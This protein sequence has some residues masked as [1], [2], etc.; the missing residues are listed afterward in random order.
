LLFWLV[1]FSF[2]SSRSSI[3]SLQDKL[4]NK[5]KL[6]ETKFISFNL[7]LFNLNFNR[8]AIRNIYFYIYVY[9]RCLK[10]DNECSK[11]FFQKLLAFYKPV[12]CRYIVLKFSISLPSNTIYIY[13]ILNV[14]KVYILLFFVI[15]YTYSLRIII[16][17][18]DI[19][20][21]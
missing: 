5:K 6:N 10:Y 8:S 13:F 20:V 15:N 4:Q 16:M 11:L 9:T 1:F 21:S 19:D 2:Y 12:F 14:R 7:K 3:S 17:K 18:L